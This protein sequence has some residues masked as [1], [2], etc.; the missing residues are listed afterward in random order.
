MQVD[1]NFLKFIILLVFGPTTEGKSSTLFVNE[2]RTLKKAPS[3]LYQ[4]STLFVNESRTLKKQQVNYIS[5]PEGGGGGGGVGYIPIWLLYG[6]MGIPLPPRL[7]TKFFFF[8]CFLRFSLLL[9]RTGRI[10]FNELVGT[11]KQI[12]EFGAKRVTICSG[13]YFY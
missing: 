5:I 1:I 13:L 2:S 12:F 3:K 6:H 7:T 9:I 4:R 8:F 11:G 10:Q